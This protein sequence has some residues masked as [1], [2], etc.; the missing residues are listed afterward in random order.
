MSLSK[1][2]WKGSAANQSPGNAPRSD[3]DHLCDSLARKG[4]A[5]RLLIAGVC[6]ASAKR[7]PACGAPR[8]PQIVLSG[9]LPTVV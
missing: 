4:R 3:A 6:F 5:P 9:R 7:E 2:F 1:G 8:R